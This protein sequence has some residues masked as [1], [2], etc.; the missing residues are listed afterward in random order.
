MS[1]ALRAQDTNGPPL[2]EAK[3]WI[4]SLWPFC[5]AKGGQC[6]KPIANVVEAKLTIF[7]GAKSFQTTS[8]NWSEIRAN[9][10]ENLR[11]VESDKKPSKND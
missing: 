10:V 7:L 6:R 3:L 11:I 8:A 1:R 5:G 4:G 2:L 9:S